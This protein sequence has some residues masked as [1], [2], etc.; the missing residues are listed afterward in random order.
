MVQLDDLKK[1]RCLALLVHERWLFGECR[2]QAEA[3]Y[4]ELD[5]NSWVQIEPSTKEACWVVSE[6]DTKRAHEA[7]TETDIH[8][9]VRD[10][11]A[12][13][14]LNGQ[15]IANVY[16]KKLGDRIEICVEFANRTDI[17]AHYNLITHESSLYFIKD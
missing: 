2:G 8:Y 15:Q 9:R 12:D 10:I 17:T 13:Y 7:A 16:Q 3:L 1:R 14:K 5:D 6:S 4:I 11:G